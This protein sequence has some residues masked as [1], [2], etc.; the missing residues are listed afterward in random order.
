LNVDQN[1]IDINQQTCYKCFCSN[2]SLS[3]SEMIRYTGPNMGVALGFIFI[4]TIYPLI[5][6]HSILFDAALYCEHLT[7][8]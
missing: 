6:N 4:T 8:V 2:A 7:T 3:S 1:T 5:D